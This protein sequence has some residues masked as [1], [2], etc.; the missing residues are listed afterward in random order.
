MHANSTRTDAKTVVE[1]ADEL[2]TV[3]PW[4]D[5][6]AHR[7]VRDVS[8][9]LSADQRHLMHVLIS[10][11][12]Y[13]ANKKLGL[14]VGECFRTNEGLASDLGVSRKKAAELACGIVA[15]TAECAV[16]V[17]RRPGGRRAT[18]DRPAGRGA[19]VYRLAL[20]AERMPAGESSPRGVDSGRSES[21]PRRAD[22]ERESSPRGCVESSPRGVTIP[23]SP[24]EGVYP[25]IKEPRGAGTPNGARSVDHNPGHD[26]L[27]TWTPSAEARALCDEHTIDCDAHARAFRHAA[28]KYENADGLDAGFMRHLTTLLARRADKALA[29]AKRKAA[30][31][32][33]R[34][35]GKPTTT[36]QRT[37][38]QAPEA[39]PTSAPIDYVQ[40]QRD[41]QRAEREAKVRKRWE[42]GRKPGGHIAEPT[43][44]SALAWE[45]FASVAR[46]LFDVHENASFTPEDRA[47]L[48]RIVGLTA[49]EAA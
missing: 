27:A 43:I 3:L 23:G 39:T 4:D 20:I 11:A 24:L 31:K 19:T 22:S 36:T 12:Q 48:E 14:A 2:I 8:C 26:A 46:E 28:L 9:P 16:R 33:K 7:C 42:G 1:T 37:T 40:L 49:T 17:S 35:K 10:W 13:K 6:R 41:E 18:G 32:T 29:S 21:S 38:A 25:S 34:G 44:E 45:A 47:E 30:S 15:A 5:G